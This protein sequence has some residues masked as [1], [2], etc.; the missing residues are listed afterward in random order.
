M[1]IAMLAMLAACLL[2]GEDPHRGLLVAC[3]ADADP[4]IVDAAE[5]IRTGATPLL[6]VLAD[7]RPIAAGAS[8]AL[9]EG[10]RES[11]AWNHVIV[12]G[13]PNDALVRQA[14]QHEARVE[15][16]GWSGFGFGVVAGEVGWIESGFNPWLHSDAIA[17]PPYETESIVITGS[18]PA[19]VAAAAT[20]FLTQGLVNGLVALPGWSRPQTT[21]LDRDPLGDPALPIWLPD[22]IGDWTRI[23]LTQCGADVGRG[24]LAD[25]GVEPADCWLVKYHRPGV[26]DGA[27]AALARRHFITGL[28]RRAFADAILLARFA[29]PGSAAAALP[30]V[31]AAA[32]LALDGGRYRDRSAGIDG[33]RD[34][35]GP[36]TAWAVGEWLA[37][38][39][40]PEE[41]AP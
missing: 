36:L 15:S 4:L 37:L 32:K 20:A 1:R 39:T 12:V 24:I 25:A 34:S 3:A 14:W 31:A 26:W 10:R 28:H 33:E 29:D 9:A 2:A 5:R 21:L 40:L 11:L 27:G 18:T 6:R 16:G 41:I 23:A 35:D 30:K 13:L 38:S 19:G 7:G 8:A 22:Q 17:K